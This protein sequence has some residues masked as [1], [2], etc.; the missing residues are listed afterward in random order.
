MDEPM[1]RSEIAALIEESRSWDVETLALLPPKFA[2]LRE[3]VLM[4]GAN[5]DFSR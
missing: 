2:R 3:K 4:D 1:S 5:N